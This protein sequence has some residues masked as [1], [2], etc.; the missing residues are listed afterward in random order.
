MLDPASAS[1]VQISL[2]TCPPVGLTGSAQ[3][4]DTLSDS[5]PAWL[6]VVLE[7]PK[8]SPGARRRAG[9]KPRAARATACWNRYEVDVLGECDVAGAFMKALVFRRK[10][11]N[12]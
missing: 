9:L 8:K 7:S 2:I 6:R 4:A 11:A 5:M 1:T 10:A 12:A 3:S